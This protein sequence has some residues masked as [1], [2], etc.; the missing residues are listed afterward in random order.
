LLQLP[1]PTKHPDEWHRRYNEKIAKRL[2]YGAERNSMKEYSVY[3]TLE[4]NAPLFVLN[5]FQGDGSLEWAALQRLVTKPLTLVVVHGIDW[6]ADMT[7]YP[8]VPLFKGDSYLGKGE[9]HLHYLMEKVIPMV[10]KSLANPP[11]FYG[12]AG[13]SLAG[14]FACSTLFWDS[15]FTRVASA[16]GSLWYP[17]FLDFAK[18][19]EASLSS[20]QVSL[21][22]G[23]RESLAKNP[24]LA[25]VGK[26]TE[27]F[28]AFLQ[29]RG[30]EA[31]FEWNEGNHFIDFDGRTAR[32]IAKLL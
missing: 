17:G 4:G 31:S 16:S 30:A 21:S 26:K 23:N 11:S 20:K 29:E 10:E 32:A 13:Y 3:G 7:P 28:L 5:T 19:H 12:I 22:L 27:E 2:A 14:L 25:Q 15:P 6:D 1:L 24:T 9:E 18:K 8:S